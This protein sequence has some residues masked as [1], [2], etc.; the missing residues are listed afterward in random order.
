MAFPKTFGLQELKKGF[1]PHLFNTPANQ[2]YRGS[3]A[4]AEHY[5]PD[6]MNVDTFREFDQWYAEKVARGVEFHFKNELIMYCWSDVRLLKEGCLRFMRDFQSHSAF[7]PFQKI[8]IS[9]CIAFPP[10]TIASEPLLGW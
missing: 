3:I 8:G 7:D 2:E 5:M 10:D 6:G 9:V 4:D 1:F